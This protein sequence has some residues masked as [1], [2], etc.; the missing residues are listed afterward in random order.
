MRY[1]HGHRAIVVKALITGFLLW[2]L[3]WAV[4][5]A[6]V[7]EHS[8]PRAAKVAGRFYPADRDEL[9]KLA[10]GLLDS[11]PEPT[12]R[13]KPRALIVP[14]AGYPY[15]G[16]V[17]AAGFRHLVG[18]TYDGVVVVGFTHRLQFDGASVDTRA[19]YQTPL[20]A[21]PVHQEAVARLVRHPGLS[22]IE[23]AHET[24]EH[25]LE[26]ELPFLQVA[27]REFR[28]IPVLMGTADLHDARQLASALADLAGS[29]DYLFVFSTD[30]SHYRAYEAAV[31]ID[32]GTVEA[33]QFETPEAVDRLFSRGRI[34]A[35]GR[36]PILTSLLLAKALGYLERRPILYA[37]SGET[38]GSTASVVGYASLALF[39]PAAPRSPPPVS[40][41]A[42]AALVQAA[43]L[44]LD[45]HLRP[46]KYANRL[47]PLGL[48]GYPE[49][50]Q[51]RGVFVT[52][53][54][55]GALRGCIGR[56]ETPEPLLKTVPV[57]VMESALQDGRFRPVRAEELDELQVE[58]SVLSPPAKLERLEDLVPGRDGVI[59]E[60]DG[61]RGVFLPQVWDETG[62]T[63]VE[64]LQELASQKAGLPPDAWKR[65]TLYVFQDYVFAEPR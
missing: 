13:R 34:E 18:H 41:E 32:Q 30:L 11:A 56:I 23:E 48:E 59:L 38:A 3:A 28:L 24:D 36:G 53:R 20:G 25:S 15:S 60:L 57:V 51:A 16:A 55:H 5:A 46:S 62:W 19:S 35:C 31:T 45:M 37:N 27:L 2:P 9:A 40:A 52:L 64:F 61:R 10:G 14:H 49:L 12:D 42:G 6:P 50:Q 21:I 26:V 47:V 17:A 65:A 22:H 29:G 33:L 43:R 1:L 7:A 44:T 63:R 58:V 4:A 39:E 8:E 54:K